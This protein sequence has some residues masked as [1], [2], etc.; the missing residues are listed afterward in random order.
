MVEC[1]VFL[2]PLG[3]RLAYTVRDEVAEKATTILHD[4]GFAPI[5]IPHCA[6]ISIIGAGMAGVPGIMARVAEVL[7][8]EDIQILQ[9]A[10]S[11]TTIWVLVK[12]EDMFAAVR[13]LHKE[14]HLHELD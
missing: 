5:L 3:L 11:H 4:M 10:D 8:K 2:R 6:K 13:A 12:D 9:C 1:F 7:T 14:F